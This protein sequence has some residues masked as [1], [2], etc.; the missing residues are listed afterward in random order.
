[1][2]KKLDVFFLFKFLNFKSWKS[3]MIDSMFNVIKMFLLMNKIKM[4]IKNS[5]S[6]SLQIL[7]LITFIVG[8]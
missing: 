2:K 8:I 3:F 4:S 7:V 5:S 6:I 1:M